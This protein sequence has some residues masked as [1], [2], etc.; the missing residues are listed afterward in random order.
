MNPEFGAISQSLY[1]SGGRS[2]HIQRI[3]DRS[4]DFDEQ[5]SVEEGWK[6]EKLDI[7]SMI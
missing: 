6:A 1:G 2:R 3:G 7:S 5:C 4:R